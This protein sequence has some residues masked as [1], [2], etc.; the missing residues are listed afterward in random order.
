MQLSH[1]LSLSLRNLLTTAVLYLPTLTPGWLKTSISHRLT[2]AGQFLTPG[3]KNV[4]CC[5]LAWHNFQKYVNSNPCKSWTKTMCKMNKINDNTFLAISG[6]WCEKHW[7][8]THIYSCPKTGTETADVFRRLRNS[9]EDFRLLREFSEMIGSSKI[10][11]LPRLYL[12]KRW[13]AYSWIKNLVLGALVCS[14]TVYLYS[15]LMFVCRLALWAHQNTAQLIK[16]YSDTT[17]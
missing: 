2:L 8:R 17:H 1:S 13:Q 16:I 4:S 10:L 15:L 5:L 14:I 11:A 12:K 9:S 3:W 7:E 6:F